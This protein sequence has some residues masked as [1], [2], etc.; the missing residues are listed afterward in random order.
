MRLWNKDIHRVIFAILFSITIVFFVFNFFYG[1]RIQHNDGLGWDG[2]AY[3]DW[4]QRDSAEILSS[5]S[6]SNY[7]IGRILPS[8]IVHFFS[9]FTGYDISTS[10]TVIKAF[11]IY[12][13]VLLISIFY[14]LCLIGKHYKWNDKVYFLAFISVFFN[15]PVLKNFSYNPTLTDMSG[16]FLGVLAFY[17][18]IRR[19]N[20]AIL[21]SMLVGAFVWPTVIYACLAF[22]IFG[23]GVME[24]RK[25]RLHSKMLGLTLPVLLI[26]LAA[27]LFFFEGLKQLNGTTSLNKELLPLSLLLFVAYMFSAVFRFID[28]PE[29]LKAIKIRNLKYALMA[30]VLFMVTKFIISFLSNGDPGPLTAVKYLGLFTQASL[31]NPLINVVAHANHYGPFYILLIFIWPQIVSYAKSEGLGL[32]AFC[33]IFAFLSIGCESR[34]FINAWPVFAL[35][36]CHVLFLKYHEN[37]TWVFVYSMLIISLVTSRFWLDINVGVWTGNFQEFPDQMLYMY[38]GPWMSHLMYSV[39]AGLSI[40]VGIAVYSLLE[41]L[42]P[43]KV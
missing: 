39:F 16:Y 11:Y 10:S 8:F 3:A 26:S 36:S 4:A 13:S 43:E 40:V 23:H 12:N 29:A 2:A 30:I 19:N 42:K 15:Y 18:Y 5:K 20:F 6:V 21:L 9:E 38:S 41:N 17:F 32:V 33:F 37:I 28:I 24:E 1:E 25:P 7:Y 31:T 14:V 22:L 27:Y 35:I 34:Q